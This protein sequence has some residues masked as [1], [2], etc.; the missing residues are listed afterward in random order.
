[1]GTEGHSRGASGAFSRGNRLGSG[2]RG[3]VFRMICARTVMCSEWRFDTRRFLACMGA[4]SFGLIQRLRAS[5]Y[6]M[7]TYES[8]GKLL[9]GGGPVY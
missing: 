6:F 4:S 3:N 5:P 1:M 8:V 2:L 9:H 7:D